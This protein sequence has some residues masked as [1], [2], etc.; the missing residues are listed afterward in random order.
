M[1]VAAR[2]FTRPRHHAREVTQASRSAWDV[3][4]ES[5]LESWRAS[6]RENNVASGTETSC[7]RSVLSL[8]QLRQI[9]SELETL[10]CNAA[11]ANF[12]PW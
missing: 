10:G 3:V 9:T 1:E 11:A 8:Q 12:R 7:I 5:G 4:G 2:S 6:M